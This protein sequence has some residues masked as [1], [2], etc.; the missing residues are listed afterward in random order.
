MLNLNEGDRRVMTCT[1]VDDRQLV[2]E[3]IVERVKTKVNKLVMNDRSVIGRL[4]SIKYEHFAGGSV[5]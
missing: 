4:S 3:E 5:Y 2:N 1:D